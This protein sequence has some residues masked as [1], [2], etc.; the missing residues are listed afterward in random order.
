MKKTLQI[1]RKLL[2]VMKLSLIQVCIA[3]IF[4][5]VSLA[6]NAEAQE[7]LNR[8]VSIH[9]ENQDFASAISAFEKQAGVKFTYRAK[10][11][12]TAQK[13]TLTAN[14][15][16]LAHVLD[17]MLAPLKIK[18]KVFN[19]QLVL[20]RLVVVNQIMELSSPVNITF[21]QENDSA[22]D[23]TVKGT[24]TDENGEKL[25]GVS[26]TVKGTTRGS[27]TNTN[28]EYSI[29]VHDD[30][31]ILVFSFVGYQG[32]EVK[33]GNRTN[34]NI[35]LKI[36]SQALNELVVVGYGQVKKSDLT[37]SV[38]SVKAKDLNAF[39]LTN[40]TQAL[41]GRAAGVQVTQNSGEPG[42]SISVRI[43][44]GNSLRASND[45]LYV[46]DGFP[47]TG[48]PSA[49]NPADIESV[50]VLKDASATAIYGSRGANGVVMITSK[51]GKS[52]KGQIDF[53]SYYG[54]QSPTK[55]LDL[56][57][58]QQFA[59]IA[60]ERATND[61]TALPFTAAQISG[62]GEGTNWQKEIFRSA[63]IQN[64][65]LNISGGSEKTQ[66]SI[67][68]NYQMQDGIIKASEYWK[69]TLRANINQKVNDIFKIDF[70]TIL[71]RTFR[72]ILNSNNSHRGDGVLSAALVASP[73]LTPYAAN[74]S[75]TN[76]APYPFSP[77]VLQNPLVWAY[78]VENNNTRDYLL[79]N[80]GFNI[81]PMKGLVFRSTWGLQLDASRTDLYSTR[82][83][84]NTPV[85]TGNIGIFKGQNV[86]N[87]NT[88]NCLKTKGI[89]EFNL[90]AGFTFQ[91]DL[92]KTVN[93]GASGFSTDLFETNS[94]QS[95]S[96]PGT[97]IS[98]VSKSKLYS[99]L[100]RI[101]YTLSS[102]YLF[103]ASF[104]ADGS[105]RFSKNNKWGYFPSAAFAWRVIEED[106]MKNNAIFS[107]LKFRASWGKSG[108][109]ALAP[110]QTLN[111]L[112]SY[113][114]IFNAADLG[115]GFAPGSDFA[116]P[117]LKWETTAQTD[118]GL[119]MAFLNNRLQFTADYYL[120]NTQDLLAIVNLPLS[121]GYAST[122]QNI[123]SIRNQG[124]EL[125]FDANIARGAFKWNVSSNFS[126]NRNKAVSLAG[127]RDVF[128]SV[129]SNPL[130]VAVNLVRQNE[131]VGVFFGFME[132]GL[133]E[134]GAI[135]YKD[136]DV[137]GTITNNDRTIIGN[138]NP[139]M[140]YGFSSTMAY[141]NFELNLFFQGVQ[142]VD[143]FN[144]N[145]S[146]IANSFTFGENQSLDFYNNRWKASQPDP[147]AKYPKVSLNTRFRESDRYVENGSYLRLKNIQLA[148]NVPVTKLGVKSIRNA[149]LYVSGQNL[150][151]FTKYSWYDPEVS[152]LGGS[153]SFSIGI[154]RNGYPNAK[155][156]TVGIRLGL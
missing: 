137:S 41:Q 96:V 20:S 118:I 73:T 109:T 107:D 146:G 3:M 156:V 28:G 67:S 98:G 53:D 86:V 78:E 87:E 18:Y 56:M 42:G 30:N 111:L 100:G 63:P 119:D 23:I 139:D 44:G 12:S 147:T 90:L 155:I 50:E 25:P 36:D 72:N 14:N 154:D 113:Q 17:K 68:G 51:R 95:G 132:D 117:E 62:F 105:S 123:G 102:R 89:H 39:P 31:A 13:I 2:Y 34:I 66:Y 71:S 85:G 91:D 37:G 45:P 22:A 21:N 126:F 38:V 106:F 9:I 26:T 52:G 153:N 140:I 136:L 112:N 74:G 84:L 54:I 124:V 48:S 135:K 144:W 57:N 94:L 120:K 40:P 99:Y 92:S 59:E 127:G 151:T 79:T 43:R 97:P 108:N 15:E 103:T 69:G 27:T 32:Q 93:L 121:A 65:S 131:P 145:Q 138:P 125:G 104:R 24:V 129:L 134:K 114:T 46:V 8:T 143:I 10:L 148:Y 33:V 11:V 142:G 70:N 83:N 55:T 19:N 88:V 150:L 7:L 115:I 82:K 49:L 81:E 35:T 149:Q 152:T 75:Y 1:K 6:K 58:A 80:I 47:I 130:A 77:N 122:V 29:S 110:Y 128:G 133:D 76:L 141:K 64:H 101:N 61:A 60:N 116:N 16:Q 4:V 5:G